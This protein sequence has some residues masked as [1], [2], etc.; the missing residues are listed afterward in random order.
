MV[1]CLSSLNLINLGRYFFFFFNITLL[2][3]SIAK[4]FHVS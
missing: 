2:I 3:F 4:K 1:V